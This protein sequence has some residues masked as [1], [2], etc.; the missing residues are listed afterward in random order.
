MGD[1]KEPISLEK[2]LNKNLRIPKY[3]RPYEW[4]EE[5]VRVLLDDLLLFVYKDD[6]Q[7]ITGN[8]IVNKV[9]ELEIV[10]VLEIVDGQQRMVTFHLLLYALGNK[11]ISFL[12]QEFDLVSQVAISTNYNFIVNWLRRF[13]KEESLFFLNKIREKIYFFY[14][15]VSSLEEAFQLFDSQNTRGKTLKPT[16][17]LKAYH[18]QKMDEDVSEKVKRFYV[19]KWEELSKNN[20]LNSFFEQHLFRIRTW[21]KGNLK[22]DFENIDVDEFK[23]IDLHKDDGRLF[24]KK[25][26]IVY[27]NYNEIVQNKKQLQFQKEVNYPFQ[28]NQIIIDGDNFFE[29]V[30]HFYEFYESLLNVSSIFSN[31]YNKHCVNYH[32]WRRTGDY[33]L[34]NVFENF[35]FYAI[36]R[37]GLKEYE[38]YQ[39]KVYRN[40]YYPRVEKDNSRINVNQ[41]ISKNTWF[42]KASDNLN[43]RFI[44]TE[45]DHYE[46]IITI[47]NNSKHENGEFVKNNKIKQVYIN[48]NN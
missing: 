15:E 21:T 27:Y 43:L 13:D 2:I 42:R 5:H 18:L 48:G 38:L 29:Y 46:E 28:I 47:E 17:L 45:K 12:M 11:E 36:T 33:Y 23:G 10:D 7:Y 4:T 20:K 9:S 1:S 37:F 41:A 14:T 44:E 34:R 35:S 32:G 30:F 40:F 22:Y 31:F 16:D 39:K 19:D 25:E 24:M 26:A 6:K 3:Q 8:I